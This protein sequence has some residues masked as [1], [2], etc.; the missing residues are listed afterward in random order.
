M[1]TIAVSEGGH[2][3]RNPADAIGSYVLGLSCLD[4]PD[5]WRVS[6]CFYSFFSNRSAWFVVAEHGARTGI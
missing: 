4:P 1:I 6:D 2:P 5:P 3:V